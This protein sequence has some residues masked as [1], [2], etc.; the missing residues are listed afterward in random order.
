MQLAGITH[1]GNCLKPRAM[2]F[3]PPA[4]RW[5]FPGLKLGFPPCWR[6]YFLL[7]RQKRSSQSKGDPGLRGRLS[8]IPCATRSRRGLRNSPA[9]Q[10]VLALFPPTSPLLGA[11]HGAQ[12][13]AE[14]SRVP[15]NCLLRSTNKKRQKIKAMRHVSAH[16][17]KLR[18]S[19]AGGSPGSG[20]IPACA[21]M[22]GQVLQPGSFL[23]AP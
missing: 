15:K 2:A 21:G 9:A 11:P 3:L 5:R 10:T 1:T 6:A 12:G 7:L 22:T 20:W 18:H 17:P 16:T 23:R 8:R 4:Q 19:R 13:R 14:S